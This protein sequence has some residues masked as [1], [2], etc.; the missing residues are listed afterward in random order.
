MGTTSQEHRYYCLDGAGR[1]HDATIIDAETDKDAVQIVR[2]RHPDGKC[3][4]WQGDRFVAKF[5]PAS[6]AQGP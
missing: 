2:T 1:L 6:S 5:D 3:E 4:V